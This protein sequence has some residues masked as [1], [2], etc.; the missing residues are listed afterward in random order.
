MWHSKHIFEK[1]IWFLFASLIL[2]G[3]V[4]SSSTTNT[5]V[6]RGIGESVSDTALA[7]RVKTRLVKNSE[8]NAGKIDVDVY[9]GE[10]TL[11]GEVFSNHEKATAI[12]ITKETPGVKKVIS[13]LRVVQGR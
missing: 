12:R 8:I 5:K 13:K 10:V 9:K 6:E 11:N 3:C 1:Y 4:T 2:A 7:A